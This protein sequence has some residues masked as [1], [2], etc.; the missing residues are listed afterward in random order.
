MCPRNI[1]R[2]PVLTTCP[3]VVGVYLDLPNIV[4]RIVLLLY[5][6]TCEDVLLS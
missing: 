3:F 5:Y 6:R 1:F 2:S 4:V